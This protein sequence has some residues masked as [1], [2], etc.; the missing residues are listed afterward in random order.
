MGMTLREYIISRRVEYAKK[1]LS[2]GK[3][4]SEACELSGFGDYSNFIRTFTLIA[5][6]SPGKYARQQANGE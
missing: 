2:E 5:G 1:L 3:N 6:T 4:V